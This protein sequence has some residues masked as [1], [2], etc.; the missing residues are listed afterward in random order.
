MLIDFGLSYQSS[1][2]EDQAVD[3]YV[4]ERALIST[5]AHSDHVVRACFL[6]YVVN[7]VADL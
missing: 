4:L 3:L 7:L 5:H 1:M 2:N 6:C